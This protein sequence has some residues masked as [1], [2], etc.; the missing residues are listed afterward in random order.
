MA[1]GNPNRFSVRA[2]GAAAGIAL[3]WGLA[4]AAPAGASTA[5]VVVAGETLSGIAAANGLSTETL[6]SWNGLSADYLVVEGT[7]INVPTP[8][9]TGVT[10]TAT[11]A[12]STTSAGGHTVTAGE[13][14]SSI[15]YANGVSV[16]DLAATNGMAET[17]LL[18]E[19]TT[20]AI[21]AASTATATSGLG[22]VDSP[23]GTLY[24]DAS[25][26][27]NW[28]AMR[29]A[30]LS[31]YGV[32]IYPGGTLSAYRTSEQQNE[33]YQQYLAGTGAPANPPGYSSHELG[34][35]VDVPSEDMA[36]VIGEIGWQYGWGRYE[37][38]DEWWHMTY[39]GG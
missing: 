13:T 18:I 14:L 12:T 6:A 10:S 9:E 11:T 2:A 24:L 1:G 29:D 23:Y 35:S 8:E 36:S 33:L 34:L 26:A 20:L 17:D 32:D 38:P 31:Q 27:D 5:H 21:P 19:G 39:G 25:A 22:S 7:T 16:A 15:A 28:N 3:A 37:A 4:A 30:S